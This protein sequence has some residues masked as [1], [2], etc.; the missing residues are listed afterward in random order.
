MNFQN[1]NV[2]INISQLIERSALLN[3]VN[4][5]CDTYI[6]DIY[7]IEIV[8]ERKQ[9]IMAARCGCKLRVA[10]Y[11]RDLIFDSHTTQK[12]TLKKRKNK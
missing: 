2:E 3:F 9:Q 7:K 5:F 12:K 1:I 6:K 11:G 8:V 4:L 10:L